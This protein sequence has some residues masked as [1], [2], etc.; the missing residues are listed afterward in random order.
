MGS[1]VLCAHASRAET[2]LQT[3]ST[4]MD[5]FCGPAAAGMRSVAHGAPR[6]PFSPT[7]GPSPPLR[8][9]FGHRATKPL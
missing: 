6:V 2:Q 5:G 1:G 4:Y 9:T 3:R 7:R 8:R